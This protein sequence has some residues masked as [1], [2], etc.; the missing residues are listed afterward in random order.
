VEY[1]LLE[2][3]LG[4]RLDAVNIIDADACVITA[5]G[6]D[7]QEWLGHDVDTIAI[8]KCG[9]ARAGKPCV[10]ADHAAPKTVNESLQRIG[11]K[12][13]RAGEAYHFTQ[14]LFSGFEDQTF[15]WEI[16]DGMIPLNAA[17]A[18]AALLAVGARVDSEVFKAASKR[19]RLRGRREHTSVDELSVVMDV[20]HNPDAC[21]ELHGFLQRLP[22]VHNTVA[23]FAVMSDKDCRDMIAALDG[24]I[25]FWC[26]PHGVGGERGQSP[27]ELVGYVRG[28]GQVFE[29]FN[30]SL[31][32]AIARLAGSGR[33][34]IFG[35][36]FTVAAGISGLRELTVTKVGVVDG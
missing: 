29:T 11:A 4:G 27:D 24:D 32:F 9:I 33:L 6:L 18:V 1:Q 7:H 26:L 3:G 21:Q 14:E 22:K 15:S 5:I 16:P 36:F 30:E 13:I 19:L 28:N 10:V 25:D 23:V 20:A 12:A 2:V 35:S 8:E 17:A 31:E 34:L